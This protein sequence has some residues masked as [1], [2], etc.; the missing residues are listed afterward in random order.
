MERSDVKRVVADGYDRLRKSTNSVNGRWNRSR[1]PVR[2]TSHSC[3]AALAPRPLDLPREVA[4]T[5]LDRSLDRW[6]L[7]VVDEHHAAL[8]E[9]PAH[10]HQI[11][12]RG[13]EPVI[14]VDEREIEAPPLV[15]ESREHELRSLFVEV[16]ELANPRLLQRVESDPRVARSSDRVDG[17]LIGV[18]RHVRPLGAV[19]EK[20][21]THEQ[22]GD[23][24]READLDGP[25]GA[26]LDHAIAERGALDRSDRDGEHIQEAPFGRDHGPVGH[27][28]LADR[29]HL[30]DRRHTSTLPAVRPASCEQEV[31]LGS[32]GISAQSPHDSGRAG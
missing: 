4:D 30:V 20:A 29:A 25:Q 21:F 26:L 7:R 24:E 18:D 12:E 23:R 32:G 11:E 8:G 3:A 31:L 19:R 2:R 14:A 13:L 5:E 15:Q 28:L 1:G 9:Q 16:D 10:V 6:K 17:A 22:G 27:K